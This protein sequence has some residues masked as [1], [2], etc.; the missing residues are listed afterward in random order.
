MNS[1][2]VNDCADYSI[3]LSKMKGA[4][5]FKNCII[6]AVKYYN[7]GQ[8]SATL[9]SLVGKELARRRREQKNDSRQL[10]LFQ[11]LTYRRIQQLYSA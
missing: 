1:K 3:K 4:F 10:S 11:F 8:Y 7:H 6:A 2:V 5:D 9:A